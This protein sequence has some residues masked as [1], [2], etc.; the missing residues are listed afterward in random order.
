[1]GLQNGST[2]AFSHLVD[3][4]L[5]PL[6]HFLTADMGIPEADAEET[7]LDLFMT[8]HEKIGTFRHG[9]R[10]KLTTWIYQIAKNRAIDYH[11]SA[12]PEPEP[13]GVGETIGQHPDLMRHRTVRTTLDTYVQALIPSKRKAQ[14]AVVKRPCL[15]KQINK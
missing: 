10:A 6:S 2:I 5:K 14:E 4:L 9:G 15:P 11:R 1:V 12:K 7:A 13:L 8:V 3:R